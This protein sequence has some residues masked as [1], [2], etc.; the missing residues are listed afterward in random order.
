LKKK[1]TIISGKSILQLV[2][3]YVEH[4]T[5]NTIVES[6]TPKIDVTSD[7]KPLVKKRKLKIIPN[8][9]INVKNET[10]DLMTKARTVLKDD[11]VYFNFVDI[12]R[13]YISNKNCNKFI[14]SLD[15]LFPNKT[16]EIMSV[17]LD[18]KDFFGKKASSEFSNYCIQLKNH[19]V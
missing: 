7:L 8:K 15:E 11:R 13:K 3:N 12:V 17:L 10:I 4:Q 1:E 2:D 6:Q 5:V 19:S 18:L 16:P 14:E 9:T